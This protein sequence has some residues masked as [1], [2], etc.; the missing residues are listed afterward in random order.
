MTPVEI[1][2]YKQ[3]WMS[4]GHNHPV[5]IHSDLRGQAKDWCKVQLMKQQWVHRKY[6]NVYEDTFFFEYHQD[7][8]SFC[9]H[10]KK[11]IINY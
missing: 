9:N 5:A 2:E 4:S 8:D 6:T 1:A 7:A 11:W 3:R 10:F